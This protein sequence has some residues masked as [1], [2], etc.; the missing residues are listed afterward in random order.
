MHR[1]L[2]RIGP[3]AIASYGVMV[4]IAFIMGIFVA[5]RRAKKYGVLPERVM[6]L[7]MVI[8]IGSIIGARALYV[9]THIS[10]YRA[11]PWTMFAV[12]QGGLTFY[13]GFILAFI[14]SIIYLKSKKISI[15]KMADIIA[16]AIALGIGFGRIGCFLNGCC[17]GKPTHFPISVVFPE[18]S[19][20]GWILPGQ[21]V[22]PTQIYSSID[23]FVIFLILL[24]IERKKKFSGELFWF[25]VLFY[26]LFRFCIDFLRWYEPSAYVFPNITNNQIISALLFLTSLI[27]IVKERKKVSL[28]GTGT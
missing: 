6:D 24:V 1:I 3:F 12:W 27:V 16:P 22:H 26:S 21:R 4:A 5:E 14:L 10:E 8:L 9:F 17:F 28:K 20:C 18:Y 15:G 13:G 11:N 2:I 19:P 7:S 25:F 23:G